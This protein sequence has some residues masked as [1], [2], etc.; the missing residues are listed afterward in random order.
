MKTYSGR[1][2]DKRIEK[3]ERT[4]DFIEQCGV[5]F[6]RCDHEAART[7]EMCHP[8]EQA[9]EGEIC[10]N[11]FLTN[12][13][14]TDYYLLCMPGNKPFK[15]KELSSQLGTA[16]LSFASGEEMEELLNI[17]PGSLSVFGLLFDDEK[18]VRLIIDEDLKNEEFFCCHPC[19]NTSSLKLRTEDVF[20]K[21]IPAMGYEPT[22]VRL[23]GE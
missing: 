2:A 16:R 13:Q 23:T 6:V 14:H 3:E 10:K 18:K 19:I 7:I 1:P 15:T 12:R 9:L 4:Y 22:F 17:T 8:I 21:L 20:G 5:D 11:L